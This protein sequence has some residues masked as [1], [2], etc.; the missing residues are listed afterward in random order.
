[1][2]KI[3]VILKLQ[4]QSSKLINSNKIK[5]T[6]NLK[7]IIICQSLNK[8]KNNNKQQINNQQLMVINDDKFLSFFLYMCINQIFINH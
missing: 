5:M 1:M 2:K 6:N 7:V 3:N 4:N 8:I